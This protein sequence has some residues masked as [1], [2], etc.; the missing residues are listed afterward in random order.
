MVDDWVAAPLSEI[1][2]VDEFS[3]VVVAVDDVSS[4]IAEL[5]LH[6]VC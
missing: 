5:V 2:R 6:E 4:P 3:I 1:H